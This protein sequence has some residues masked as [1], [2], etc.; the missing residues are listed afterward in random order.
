MFDT[1]VTVVGNVLHVPELRR[2]AS[3]ALVT[4]FRIASTARR[5]D[6]ETNRWVDARSLRLRVTCWR[7]LAHNVKRS[8]TVGDPVVVTGRLF[9][10]D[11]EDDTGVK[12]VSYELEAIAVGHDLSRGCAVFERT[13]TGQSVSEVEDGSDHIVAG[14]PTELVDDAE[15]TDDDAAHDDDAPDVPAGLSTPLGDDVPEG[16]PE[17]ATPSRGG[18]RRSPVAV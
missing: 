17:P 9:T 4:T 12:R 10:R 6:R 5:L 14:E 15:H 3:G 11:W 13:R 1:Y 2:T 7:A 16:E 8:V 18:R